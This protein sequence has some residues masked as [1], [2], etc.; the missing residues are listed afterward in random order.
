MLHFSATVSK[1]A[2][3]LNPDYTPSKFPHSKAVENTFEQRKN[4]FDRINKRRFASSSLSASIST[5][6]L[7][8]NR[9]KEVDENIDSFLSGK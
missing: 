4:R 1:S 5:S 8:E 2:N 9:V 6:P 3:S 7:K